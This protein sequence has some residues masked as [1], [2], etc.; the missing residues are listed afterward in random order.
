MKTS[1]LLIGGFDM[2]KVLAVSLIEKGYK[3]TAIHPDYTKCQQLA[4]IADLQVI[5]GDGAKP[6]I[7]EEAGAAYVSIAI[8]LTDNDDDN[9]VISELCKKRFGVKKTVCTIKNGENTAFFRKM[10]VDAVVCATN[11]ITSIIEQQA[12]LDEMTTL[13]PI[14]EGRLSIAEIPISERAP[15]VGKKLWEIDLPKEVIIGCILRQEVNIIPRGD[16]RILAGDVLILLSSA[17]QEI[18]AVHALTGR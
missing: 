11:A 10:G 17:K 4:E 6:F 15:A 16:T 8:A 14:G 12:F 2:T 1:V 9:L 7:L 18:T 3:V 13:I 5:N